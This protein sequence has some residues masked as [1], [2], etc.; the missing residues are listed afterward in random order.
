MS[1]D[2]LICPLCHV[3]A[4]ILPCLPAQLSIT[5]LAAIIAAV[6]YILS[7]LSVHWNA[8]R[9]RPPY[10]PPLSEPRHCPYVLHCRYCFCRL[11]A[12][13]AIGLALSR[14]SITT[15]RSPP[16]TFC[17]YHDVTTTTLGMPRHCNS[18]RPLAASWSRTTCGAGHVRSLATIH[19]RWVERPPGLPVCCCLPATACLPRLLPRHAVIRPRHARGGE[20]AMSSRHATIS[21][22]VRPRT[23]HPRISTIL[24]PHHICRPRARYATQQRK[25]FLSVMSNRAGDYAAA[26]AHIATSVQRSCATCCCWAVGNP[27]LRACYRRCRC[28]LPIYERSYVYCCLFCPRRPHVATPPDMADVCPAHGHHRHLSPSLPAACRPHGYTSIHVHCPS[29]YAR[30][31]DAASVQHTKRHMARQFTVTCAALFSAT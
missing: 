13:S 16:I 15:V 5:L 28:C 10:Y 20:P 29:H 2:A 8:R 18:S 26:S 4:A 19:Q 24:H 11:S 7:M 1:C 6:C 22:H 23:R 12:M 14:P 25:V 31:N 30:V 17:P 27:P 3:H 9:C 21:T